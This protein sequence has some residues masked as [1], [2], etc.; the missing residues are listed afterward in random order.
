MLKGKILYDNGTDL[1]DDYFHQFLENVEFTKHV[2][3]KNY[4]DIKRLPKS[5]QDEFDV[6]KAAIKIHLSNSFVFVFWKTEK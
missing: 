3:C 2:A 4:K 1:D 6:A 5:M